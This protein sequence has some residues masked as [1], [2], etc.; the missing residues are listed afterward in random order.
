MKIELTP[1]ILTNGDEFPLELFEDWTHKTNGARDH[2]LAY[3]HDYEI[4][5]WRT[6]DGK[7]SRTMNLTGTP[8]DIREKIIEQGLSDPEFKYAGTLSRGEA[9]AG[10]LI[11]L[12]QTTD[13]EGNPVDPPIDPESRDYDGIA[14]VLD[15]G[16]GAVLVTSVGAAIFGGHIRAM[17]EQGTADYRPV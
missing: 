11:W 2:W 13:E 15:N 9:L 17:Q 8:A 5:V 7:R 4:D 12:A 10:L 14:G 1:E 16:N 3:G 6:E